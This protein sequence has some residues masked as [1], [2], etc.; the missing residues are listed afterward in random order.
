[1]NISL[2]WLR[3][4]VDWDG[5]VD[6]LVELLT[7]TGI[8]VERV[9]TSGVN[10]PKVVIGQ[11]LEST[12]HPNADRLSVCRVDDGSGTP[13]QIVCG[14]KNYKVG[15]KVPV[16]LPGAVLPGD[17]KIKTGKL[18]GVESEGML[19]SGKELGISVDAEGLLILSPDAKVGD[20]VSTLFPSGTMIELEITPNRG[21]WLGHIGVAREVAAFTGK[22]LRTPET[23]QITTHEDDSFL[24]NDLEECSFYSARVIRD[25]KV[26]P[27]PA[28]LKERL[29]SIGLR[30][31][32]NIVDITNF[33]MMET[34]HPLHAFDL[35]KVDGGIVVRMA[36][37][38]E[39]LLALDGQ[40]YSLKA[41]HL[42]IA[43]KTTPLAI[44][45]VMGGEKSGVTQA[46]QSI[47]LESA[48]FSTTSIRKTSR[49]LVLH[50]D[51]SHRFER[52]TTAEGALKAS[53]RAT[54]L[55]LEIAG[56]KADE[57]VCISGSKEAAMNVISFRYN[58][59]RDLL[60]ISLANDQI[61]ELL[62]RLG[63]QRLSGDVDASQWVV[64]V[65]RLDLHREVDLI[66]EVARLHGIESL[67]GRV[68]SYPATPTA[69]D[70]A[71][72]FAMRLRQ[73]LTALGYYEA[74]TSTL[75]SAEAVRHTA[76][77]GLLRLRNPLGEDQSYLRPS[78]LPELL[79]VLARNIRYGA[80]TIRLFEIGRVFHS[81]GEAEETSRLAL[82]LT[83]DVTDVTWRNEAKR[84]FDLFDLKGV[85]E[86]LVRGKIAFR[87]K[88]FPGLVLGL[89]IF[90][91]NKSLGCVAQ[92]PPAKAK[93]IDA[94]GPVVIAELDFAA[95]QAM[96][97]QKL[98]TREIPKF[99]A[100]S[101]DIACVMK[102][103]TS[104]ATLRNALQEA[105]EPLLVDVQLFDV[106]RD[107]SG[108]KLSANQKSLALSLT[109][110]SIERTLTSE[111][112]NATCD[113]LK[114]LL[115]K[116]LGVEFRE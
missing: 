79:A 22:T 70:H 26:G 99:P 7:R 62:G 17:F 92:L 101:R 64:P 47:L 45:G 42:V 24:R 72:D 73:K 106:F 68:I 116:S 21:D 103:E 25:V 3:D 115:K 20:A 13:R 76:E 113:R 4:Y 94:R 60:G 1:M 38:G 74:R 93:E 33:V 15:D 85:I 18:R 91:G 32:N 95:L 37:E 34:G 48:V 104:Y 29:E 12:Q 111:E 97:D 77:Q 109:F 35:A 40:E 66:E 50:S 6:E 69:G 52:G 8:K 75:V 102:V 87:E 105:R 81:G 23:I 98:R 28:W 51:S 71:Y 16:A 100:V 89:E 80:R 30:S 90:S 54:Q 86:N 14:A 44:A 43:D 65:Y 27:S 11:I 112:I 9:E 2:Q 31:I 88:E 67:V 53:A 41:T 61:D 36:K 114:D 55:I 83:G 78:I 107:A 82:A 19:C 5:S 58:R 49:D 10:I 39:K 110:R 84:T 59:C 57:S 56:G 63:I 108:N 96:D 46:T